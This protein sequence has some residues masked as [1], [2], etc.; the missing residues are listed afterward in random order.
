MTASPPHRRLPWLGP[1]GLGVLLAAGCASLA[2]E[3]AHPPGLAGH[4]SLDPAAS[5]DFDAA[6]AKM[7]A[8]RQKKRR[9]GGHRPSDFGGES[10]NDA[11]QGEPG[12]GGRGAAGLPPVPDEP[13]DRMRRRLEEALRPPGEMDLAVGDGTV[14]VT[15]AGEP[16]HVYYPGQPVGRIDTSGAARVESGWAGPMFVVKAKYQSGASRVQRYALQGQGAELSVTL[17]YSDPFSG[18]LQLRSLYRRR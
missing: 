16:A 10:A 7:I 3:P 1:L 9:A 15:A 8:D 5:D 14:S 13:P 4:W 6:L 2:P 11:G 17:A 12:A 18:N